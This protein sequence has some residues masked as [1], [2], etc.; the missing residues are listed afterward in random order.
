MYLNGFLE[1]IDWIFSRK[2][3]SAFPMNL[4]LIC[5]YNH[6]NSKKLLL[7]NVVYHDFGDVESPPPL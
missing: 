1:A 7:L 5:M 4:A 6:L 2:I 3:H